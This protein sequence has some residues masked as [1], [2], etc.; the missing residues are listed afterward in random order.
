MRPRR[1][2]W[3]IVLK[4][5]YYQEYAESLRSPETLICYNR[6][7]IFFLSDSEVNMNLDGFVELAK[8]KPGEAQEIIKRFLL[9]HKARSLKGEITMGS[10]GN[11]LKPV[12]HLFVMSDVTQVNWPKLFRL[13]PGGRRAGQDRAPTPEELKKLD[14]YGDARSKFILSAMVSGGFRVGAWP[15]LKVRDFEPIKKNEE[16][17]AAKVTV[18]RGYPEEYFCFVSP[19]CWGRYQDYLELRRHAGEDITSDSPALRNQFG[20]VGSVQV[21]VQTVKP[22]NAVGVAHIILR[23]WKRSG[24]WEATNG[25]IKRAHSLRKFYKTQ[26]ERVMKPINVETLLGHSTGVSD[27]YYRPREGDLL[28][29]YQK[30]IPLLSLSGV[31]KIRVIEDTAKLTIER[32]KREELEELVIKALKRIDTLEGLVKG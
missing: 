20:L 10:V 13:L 12:K 28:E 8:S 29:D 19:E 25:E 17:L 6:C 15:D 32:K 4:A 18:Y 16:V 24:L 27:S 23:A 7:L 21:N 31:E 26:A 11:Y 1:D 30:A 22:L 9:K 3:D 5:K 2:D 14:D